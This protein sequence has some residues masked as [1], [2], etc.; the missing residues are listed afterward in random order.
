M[1]LTAGDIRLVYVRP[2]VTHMAERL[3]VLVVAVP[4]SS[5]TL[6]QVEHDAD[7]LLEEARIHVV[8]LA[9]LN[10]SKPLLLLL[11]GGDLVRRVLTVLLVVGPFLEVVGPLVETVL[12]LDCDRLLTYKV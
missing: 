4:G 8:S 12:V 6:P 11:V 9:G 10:R 1:I 2:E 5:Q 3:A 7:V